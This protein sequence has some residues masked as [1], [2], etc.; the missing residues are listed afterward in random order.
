MLK[1]ELN[2]VM[3]IL[4]KMNAGSEKAYKDMK[5]KLTFNSIMPDNISEVIEDLVTAT[6]GGIMSK[7][8]AIEKNPLVDNS[9]AEKV[10][11]KAESTVLSAIAEPD[12]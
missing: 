7:E 5:L 2:V 3:S 9:K 4:S 8:T 10:K 11:V 1:R 6:S 12:V